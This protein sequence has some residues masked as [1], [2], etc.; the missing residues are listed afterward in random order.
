MRYT[1]Y[2]RWQND[3][4]LKGKAEALEVVRE[5]DNLDELFGLACSIDDDPQVEEWWIYDNDNYRCA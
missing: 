3:G 1:L 4:T 5:C 2:I